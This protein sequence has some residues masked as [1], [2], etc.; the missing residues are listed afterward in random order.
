MGLGVDSAG[1][2]CTPDQGLTP[3]I[4]QFRWKSDDSL[5]GHG[6]NLTVGEGLYLIFAADETIKV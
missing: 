5:F 3:G 6:A 4:D 1:E 2:L